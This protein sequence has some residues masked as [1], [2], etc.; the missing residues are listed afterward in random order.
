MTNREQKL[1]PS[2]RQLTSVRRTSNL[3]SLTG[4]PERLDFLRQVQQLLTEKKL[5]GWCVLSI[6]IEHFKLFNNW[7]GQV[8]GD[9]L[10]HTIG[11]QLAQ[12]AKENN[13]IA[14]Y[15]G[16]DDFFLCMPDDDKRAQAV[17]DLI[18]HCIEDY[19]QLDSFLPLL[20]ICPVDEHSDDISVLCNNAQIASGAVRGKLNHRIC[21]F[22]EQI[23][24]Q[25]EMHQRLLSDVRIGIQRGE[26]TFYLQP[27]CNSLTGNIVSMEALVRWHHPE[28]GLVSPSRFIPLLEETGLVTDLDRYIWESVCRTMSGWIRSGKHF[29]PISVNVSITDMKAMDVPAHFREMVRRYDLKSE[30]IRVEITET[31]FAENSN[32]VREA[33]DRL[34]QYGFT[35]LMDDFGSGYSSLNMLKDTNVDVLKLDMKF[36]EMNVENRQKGIQI[37]DS[38]VNMAHKLNMTIIAEGVETKEQVDMLKTMNCIYG[39]GYYFYRP[40]PVKDAERLLSIIVPEDYRDI[41]RFSGVSPMPAVPSQQWNTT[42]EIERDVIATLDSAYLLLARLN[43]NTGE[44]QPLKR[45]PPLPDAQMPF[46]RFSNDLVRQR[47][48][49]PEDLDDYQRFMALAHLQTEIFSGRRHMDFRFRLSDGK[50][51]NWV[52]LSVLTSRGYTQQEPWTLLCIRRTDDMVNMEA[53]R[54]YQREL[55][56]YC[57][58]DALTGLFNRMKFEK[59]VSLL[60]EEHPDTIECVYI[61]VVGL[62]EINNHLGHQTGDSMLCM[63]AGT[64]RSFFPNDRLYRIGGDEFVI[65]CCNR[66][67]DEVLLA[68]EKLRMT[69]RGAEYEISVG[70]QQGTGQENVQNIVNRA[71][72]AMRRDKEAYYQ[73]NGQERRM[74]SLNEKLERLMQEKQDA[75][76]FIRVIAPEYIAVY[77]INCAQDS[78]RKILIP[79]FFRDMLDK[80]N[81]SFRRAILEYIR[82][83]IAPEDQEEFESLTCAQ[84]VRE[85]LAKEGTIDEHYKRSDGMPIHLRI[86]ACDG[87]NKEESI[88]IF[89]KDAEKT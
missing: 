79:D 26:F 68:V 28:M 66:K 25:L 15:F 82:L 29:V 50:R 74:R 12:L 69:L 36:I 64:A 1:L 13:Y 4:L 38:V 33:I 35:V 53:D 59:D 32:L 76:Q 31:A 83:Y 17:Y 34:H 9:E 62:H 81:G 65:L 16:G 11:H 20:G 88:W 77:L 39:Q 84:I 42:P 67:H 60:N 7:Y 75:D 57:N 51:F 48:I 5:N 89:A 45:T 18:F 86:M 55:E 71:E 73:Q 70:V 52:E 23:M 54:R 56:Y 24:Q 22:S 61:D 41:Q 2:A 78:F 63:V 27:K 80:C 85:R 30:L 19:Q 58:C 47:L 8:Q 72:D 40:L 49:H 21:R 46:S 44:C 3:N 43:L 87:L 14:G 37:V 10:L 6:D